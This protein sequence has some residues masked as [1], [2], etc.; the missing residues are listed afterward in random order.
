MIAKDTQ[1]NIKD[2]V[3][4]TFFEVA[5]MLGLV[6]D[7]DF[8]FNV[9]NLRVTYS[10]GSVV[11]FK[12]LEYKPSDHDFHR[13]GG[14]EITDLFIDE[15]QTISKKAFNKAK[16]RIRRKNAEL[17]L[18][19]STLLTCNP[20]PNWVKH[21][22][23][24]DDKGNPMQLP[25]H[26]VFIQSLLSDN[27]DEKFQKEYRAMLS[28]L[29]EYEQ[30][31]Y[32]Y[33]DWDAEERTGGEFYADFEQSSN[34]SI[35]FAYRPDLPLHVSFDFNVH[36]YM[37]ATV[38][39][40]QDGFFWQIAEFCLGHPYNR[41]S[42]VC[43]AI[44]RTYSGHA[45]GLLIYGDPGGRQ[46]DTRS[47]Q[48]S[49]DYSIILRELA[50][51]RPELRLLNK[52]PSVHMRGRFI[53]DLFQGKVEGCKVVISGECR[54]TIKDYMNVKQA[55]DGGKEK[56]KVKDP[57]TGISYEPLGHTSDANDYFLCWVFNKEY[58]AWQ[59]HGQ[60]MKATLGRRKVFSGNRY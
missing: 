54:E 41:T 49:N 32:L 7:R 55:A 20:S 60:P 11:L 42:A 2:T 34:V 25:K 46:E 44:L 30:S 13:L 26:Q 19:Y 8:T 29:S 43:E 58:K 16:S 45:A 9:Q 4:P 14:Y 15:C 35:D 1:K 38:W 3:I 50:P 5:A 21:T 33:G 24:K 52:A 23:V 10:N 48:G 39:Q 36:P 51:L 12:D 22:F 57:N 47:E 27:P 17:G 18:P 28:G 31:I 53:N 59:S 40:G 56:K 6:P 37:T